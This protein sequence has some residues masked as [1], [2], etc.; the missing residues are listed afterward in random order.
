[1]SSLIYKSFY[2]TTCNSKIK[3]EDIDDYLKIIIS[4]IKEQ[5]VNYDLAIDTERI[6]LE[7]DIGEPKTYTMII[8]SSEWLKMK[9]G[10]K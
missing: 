1:M 2:Q 7:F 5:L 3:K 6:Y 8:Q 4:L 10:G 9:F